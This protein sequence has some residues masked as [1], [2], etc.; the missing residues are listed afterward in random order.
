[1]YTALAMVMIYPIAVIISYIDIVVLG[2]EL[3]G[4]IN[5]SLFFVAN[6]VL[7][8]FYLPYYRGMFVLRAQ[9]DPTFSTLKKR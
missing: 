4:N 9:P 8:L 2:K 7:L 3:A 5:G 6:T 1:V